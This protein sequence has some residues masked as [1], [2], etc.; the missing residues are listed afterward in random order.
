MGVP[1][2]RDEGP[3]ETEVLVLRHPLV[4]DGVQ[5]TVQPAVERDASLAGRV[6]IG[7][8]VLDDPGE[9]PRI[10]EKLD[11]AEGARFG[12]GRPHLRLFT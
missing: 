10:R 4:R 12:R 11:A 1:H 5:G 9:F 7:M 2:A 8:R 3:Y 6:G